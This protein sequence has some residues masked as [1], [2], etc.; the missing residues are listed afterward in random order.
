MW[1]LMIN[2]VAAVALAVDAMISYRFG[3]RR[4]IRVS[5]HKTPYL[6]ACEHSIA[7]HTASDHS[8]QCMVQF[9]RAHYDNIGTRNGHEYARCPCTGYVGDRPLT[10]T[11][12]QNL[13]KDP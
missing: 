13:L 2:L 3:L 10:P 7:A 4:G 9:K 1:S 6:C 8:G 5:S 11:D 12:I